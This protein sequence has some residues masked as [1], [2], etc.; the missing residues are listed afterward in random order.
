MAFAKTPNGKIYYHI[1]GNGPVLVLI[2]GLGRWSIHWHGFDDLLAKSFTVITTDLR[3]LGQST[4]AMRPWHTVEHLADDIAA[5]LKNERIDTASVLGCSLG[6]MVALAFAT[7]HASLLDRLIIVNSSVGRSGHQ[8]ISNDALKLILQAPL[9]KDN[10][11]EPLARLLLAKGADKGLIEGLAKSWASLEREKPMHVPTVANQLVAALRF[12]NWE[13]FSE[14]KSPTLILSSR[15]DLFVPRGNSLFL[16]D[17]I[18][19]AQFIALDDA[20]HEPHI[21]KPLEVA[22]L[23]KGFIRDA[24]NPR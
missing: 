11:Y 13:N 18:P 14:I 16:R 5:I 23:V 12:T 9:L 2:R 20:G 10:L 15:E 24:K 1:K 21:D 8:R 22:G 3:G 7:T 17:K 19:G 6:G 4:T